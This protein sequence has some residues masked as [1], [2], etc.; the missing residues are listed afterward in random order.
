MRIDAQTLRLPLILFLALLTPAYRSAKDDH[1]AL[2][3]PDEQG[4]L[5]NLTEASAEQLLG[6]RPV[7]PTTL[8]PDFAVHELWA[9]SSLLAGTSVT[10]GPVWGGPYVAVYTLWPTRA[11]SLPGGMQLHQSQ[12][13]PIPTGPG[14]MPPEQP[15]RIGGKLVDKAIAPVGDS[16]I[17]NISYRWTGATTNLH[18]L[19]LAT[20][21]GELAEDDVEALIAAL[22]D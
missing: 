8:P 9:Q 14:G 13:D 5:H 12:V 15:V 1:D 17:A 18:M 3:T 19:V 21:G 2:P 4:V 16:D 10:G 7:R 6:F 11:S 22:P 20:T